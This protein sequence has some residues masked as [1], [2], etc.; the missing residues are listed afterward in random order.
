MTAGAV[1]IACLLFG[2]WRAQTR[3]GPEPVPEVRI[4]L[5]PLGVPKNFFSTKD[6]APRVIIGYRF[7]VW[8]NSDEVAVGFNT[9]LI[10]G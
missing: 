1:A 7:V 5:S 3:A 8:L 4:D 2:C 10:P 6:D 9:T